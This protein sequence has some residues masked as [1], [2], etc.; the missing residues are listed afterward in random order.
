MKWPEVWAAI[1]AKLREELDADATAGAE[2]IGDR[3]RFLAAA[4]PVGITFGASGDRWEVQLKPTIYDGHVVSLLMN[5]C[6][7]EELVLN[8]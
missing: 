1:R 8:G 6:Q 3:E 5:G 2:T 4:R 7:C